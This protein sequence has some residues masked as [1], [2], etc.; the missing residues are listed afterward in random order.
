[1]VCSPLENLH[2]FGYGV[3]TFVEH[4]SFRS[5]RWLDQDNT[6]LFQMLFVKCNHTC[7]PTFCN[8]A[9]LKSKQKI[10]YQLL[11]FKFCLFEYLKNLLLKKI[12]KI[13]IFIA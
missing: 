2:L 6:R 4:N 7:Q 13:L 12:L 3:F 1:M 11:I 8:S 10:P 5:N 9:K